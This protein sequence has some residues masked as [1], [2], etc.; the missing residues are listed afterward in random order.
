MTLANDSILVTPGSGATVATHSANSKEYQAVMLADSSGHI[1]GSRELYFTTIWGSVGV[2]AAQTIHWDLWNGTSSSLIRIVSIKQYISMISAVTGVVVTWK[3]W[4]T[5]SSG[6]GGTD[7]TSSL[8]KHDTSQASLDA[9]ITAR[10]KPTGGAALGTQL[11]VFGMH[12]E[13]TNTGSMMQAAMGGMELVPR[14]LYEPGLVE[15]G[16]VIRPSEGICVTQETNT[17]QSYTCWEIVF[18]VE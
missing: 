13:E 1:Q 2:A 6:T 8:L 11:R 12:S 15:K 18:V 4:R 17:A 3:L 7:Y 10:L 16:L 5:T 14:A 9:N